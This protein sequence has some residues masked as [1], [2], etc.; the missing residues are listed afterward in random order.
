MN[1]LP[2]HVP[3]DELNLSR[4]L[5]WSL[6]G[7]REIEIRNKVRAALQIPVSVY[8]ETTNKHES[9]N[10]KQTTLEQRLFCSQAIWNNHTVF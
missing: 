5:H 4:N 9:C 1:R 10:R 7:I 6:N 3:F 8:L 2:G